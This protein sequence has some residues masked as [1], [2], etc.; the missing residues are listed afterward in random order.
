MTNRISI[1]L[2][3]LI[4]AIFAIDAIFLGG[5]LPVL[6]GKRVAELIEYLSFWR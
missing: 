1:V 6:L 2:V 5:T 4:I 3:L